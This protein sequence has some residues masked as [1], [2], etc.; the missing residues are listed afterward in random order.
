MLREKLGHIRQLKAAWGLV[1]CEFSSTCSLQALRLFKKKMTKNFNL[2]KSNF[3]SV[4]LS[5]LLH[6][7]QS[8]IWNATYSMDSG[9]TL[10]RG[11][12]DSR[13]K[14]QGSWL[15]STSQG[16]HWYKLLIKSLFIL[17]R[18]VL[19]LS[20]LRDVNHLCKHPCST[21]NI[22]IFILTSNSGHSSTFF[23][24]LGDGFI[25]TTETRFRNLHLRR[26]K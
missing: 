14:R 2:F 21:R 3:V 7:A 1:R 15:Y 16:K 24:C 18:Y 12:S 6:I 20:K 25:H 22:I 9:K 8:H 5:L 10:W 4:E 19:V 17:S 13:C 26:Q 11:A 23:I